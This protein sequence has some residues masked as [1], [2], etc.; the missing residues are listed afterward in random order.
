VTVAV[1]A[2]E[3]SEDDRHEWLERPADLDG[4][5]ATSLPSRSMG[6]ED[7]LFFAAALVAGTALADRLA[8]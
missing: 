5:F 4:Y 2:G 8:G 3:R 1:P 7:P 6:R